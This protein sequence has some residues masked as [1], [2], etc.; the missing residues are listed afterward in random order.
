MNRQK[1]SGESVRE[2]AEKI[3]FTQQ[4]CYK[5][6]LPEYTPHPYKSCQ[7]IAGADFSATDKGP[8]RPIWSWTNG[9]R[10]MIFRPELGR[11]LAFLVP[12]CVYSCA[13]CIAGQR[14]KY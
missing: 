5:N 12:R 7:H 13:V 9:L 14:L 6:A 11:L 2:C 10:F 4:M 8:I 1:V 3:Q